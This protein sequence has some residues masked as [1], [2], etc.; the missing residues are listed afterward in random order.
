MR[1]QT[2]SVF[3]VTVLSGCSSSNGGGPTAVYDGGIS[4]GTATFG[5]SAVGVLAVTVGLSRSNFPDGGPAVELFA[6][7]ASGPYDREFYCDAYFPGVALSAG[8]FAIP[9]VDATVQLVIQTGDSSA[10]F[11]GHASGFELSITSPG[12]AYTISFPVTLA[13][14]FSTDGGAMVSVTFA[15]PAN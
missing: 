9:D 15:P 8:S 13:P 12:P 4:T 7:N 5:G 1:L 3:A 14:L 11:W 6:T 2:F 10:D